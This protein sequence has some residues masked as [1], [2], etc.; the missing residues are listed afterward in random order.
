MFLN[1]IFIFRGCAAAP[2]ILGGQ[3]DYVF[4][5]HTYI[6]R[7]CCCTCYPRRPTRPCFSTTFSY[8][9]AVLLSLLCSE[10]S[11]TIFSLHSHVQRLCCCSCYPRRPARLSFLN[12]IHIFRGGA[13]AAAILR[14]HPDHVFHYILMFRGCAAAA[15]ILGGQPD[16]SALCGDTAVPPPLLTWPQPPI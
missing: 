3:P 2:A 11:Q 13:A 10:A 15:A 14:G 7:Q 8:S 12:Y 5:L 16:G 6:Q 9:E 1:C 4:K